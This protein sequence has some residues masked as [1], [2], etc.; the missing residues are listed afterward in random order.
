VS[1]FPQFNRVKECR[2]GMM[3]YNVNDAYIGR[4][5]HEYGEFSQGEVDLFQ[6]MVKPGMTVLEVG[7]N[8]GAHTVWLAQAVGRNGTVVAFEPQRILFQTL[9]ANLALNSITNVQC[10]WAAVGKA[11]GQ[12][13]VPPLDYARANNFG[14]LSLGGHPYGEFVPVATIDG[15]N[16]THC[17]VLK[18]DV[19]GM[20]QE[21]LEGAVQLIA[22]FAPLLY[23][24]ND[25]VEKSASLIRFI[26]SLGYNM[27]WHTPMYFSPQN[28][29]GN[30]VNV[31][32]GV[33][34]KNMLCLPKAMKQ[35]VNGMPAVQVPA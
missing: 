31:F 28:F 5:L 3:V 19:E 35:Q 25:R 6:Q 17:H 1:L 9:C 30:S 34:S 24:E 7:A 29:A 32:G 23:V 33:V 26:D 16:L 4:S 10:Y 14:A 11:P 27:Y 12:I 21:V 20:E 22:A 8:I 13:V 18:I 15:L 2:Y